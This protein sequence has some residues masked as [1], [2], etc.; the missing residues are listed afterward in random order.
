MQIIRSSV[1]PIVTYFFAITFCAG[2]VTGKIDANVFVATSTM[3]LGF[4]FAERNKKDIS[5]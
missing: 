1:R 5:E 4:W 3:V 2:F